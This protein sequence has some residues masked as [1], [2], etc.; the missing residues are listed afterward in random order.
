MPDSKGKTAKTLKDDD[1]KSIADVVRALLREELEASMQQVANKLDAMQTELA[2]L[3]TRIISAE[4]DLTSLKKDAKRVSAVLSD[5]EDKLQGF[6]RKIADLED[7][8]RR[9]NIRVYGLPEDAEKDAPV[10]YLE[11]M[12]PVWFPALKHQKPEIERAH[13]INSGGPSKEGRPRA[14]I[15]C[16]LRF[17]MRQSILR[18]ARKHPPS[19]GNRE[20]RFAADFSD[21]TAKRRRSFSRAMAMA[22]ERGTDAFLLYPATLKIK[23][24]H[25]THLFSSPADAEQFLDRRPS[26]DRPGDDTEDE[27]MAEEASA[28]SP[29]P[30]T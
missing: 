28:A 16:C 4:G 21:Y 3:N 15:F 12:I 11:R 19:V 10:Q 20:L 18:E 25:T 9:Y 23:S 13:R 7:R 17:S 8:G 6:E 27:R 24:G 5:T 2:S 14:F 22:R 26:P 30:D 1:I 29:S